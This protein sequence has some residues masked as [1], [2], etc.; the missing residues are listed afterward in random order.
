MERNWLIVYFP[1]D[2][3]KELFIFLYITYHLGIG[4]RFQGDIYFFTGTDLQ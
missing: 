1:I 4:E 3:K 2:S